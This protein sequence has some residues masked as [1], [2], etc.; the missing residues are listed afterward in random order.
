[1]NVDNKGFENFAIFYAEIK[2]VTSRLDSM[3]SLVR[4]NGR[5]LDLV[6]NE[7]RSEKLPNDDIAVPQV[8]MPEFESGT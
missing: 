4:Q 3:D 5:L 6:D 7:W 1:M 2:P 8:E